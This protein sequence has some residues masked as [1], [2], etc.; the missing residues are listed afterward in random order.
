MQL[1]RNPRPDRK[2]SRRKFLG[3]ASALAFATAVA[4]P[5]SFVGVGPARA[6]SVRS[7]VLEVQSFG[8]TGF[9][10][11]GKRPGMVL[12]ADPGD[13]IDVHF[14]NSLPL[15]PPGDNCPADHNQPHGRNTTNLHTHGL[16]VSPTVDSTGTFDADNVFLKI[17]PKGQEVPCRN[18]SFRDGETHY[19][20][21]LPPDH[22]SGT[23]WY[24]A[25]KHGSTNDQVSGGL[26]G[27]LIIRDRP[28]VMPDY[29]AQAR[30]R[31]FM[32]TTDGAVEMDPGGGGTLNPTVTLDRGSVE[33]WRIINA[34][35]S[36]NNFVSLNIDSEEVELWQI[37]YDGLTLDRRVRVDPANDAD[38]WENHAA[39]A[40][41]NRTDLMVHVPKSAGARN[42]RLAARQAST[43]FLHSHGVTALAMAKP[44]QIGI[45]VED[46]EVDDL[47][48]DSDDLPG[49]GLVPFTQMPSLTRSVTFATDNKLVIDGQAFDGQIKQTMQLDTA[50]AWTVFNDG[51][52][53]HPFH[54]HVNPF[55][56]T[57]I[58][59]K[60]LAEGSPLRRWQDVV[61][62][63][64]KIDGQK[65][66]VQ[67]ST[68]FETFTGQFVI[69]CHILFHEDVGMMQAVA[70]I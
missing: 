35:P 38:P 24:H 26:A 14:I 21:E 44:V 8:T 31:I 65:G 19:R 64:P 20:F 12:E 6:Q 22:P 42:L 3:E 68:R 50:E 52:G 18:D 48:S 17:T 54:I 13:R 37:A 32:L 49:P 11:N 62:L 45:M 36:A 39:L 29:I 5:I 57:H 30:E 70:V 23:F 1:Q 69:H 56:V 2:T 55:F 59:G 67:F 10:Y 47:W 28:G 53:T 9:A 43:E 66:S 61:A 60:E 34:N 7:Y 4:G 51:T 41:G 25:H 46:Q 33:R 27:P 58:N 16:H 15:D 40:P 63:P